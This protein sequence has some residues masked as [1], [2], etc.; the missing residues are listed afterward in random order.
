M[1]DAS[2]FD[3]LNQWRW[4]TSKDG[5][6]VRHTTVQERVTTTRWILY[7]HREVNGTPDDLLTDHANGDRLDNRKTNLRDA[8]K[9]QNNVNRGKQKNNKSGYKDVYFDVYHGRWEASIR[10]EGKKHFLGRRDSAV[11]AY[12][13]YQQASREYFG[14]Y[15]YV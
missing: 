1:V 10:F 13:L 4:Y 9:L 12:K 5:Y 3:W 2:D 15:S 8:T 14:D 11:E 6:A 7:M